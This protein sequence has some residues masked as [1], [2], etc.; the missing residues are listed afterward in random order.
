MGQEITIIRY[1]RKKAKSVLG[2]IAGAG[3]VLGCAMIRSRKKGENETD[4]K[5]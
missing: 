4:K 3:A 1:W 2:V 5:R